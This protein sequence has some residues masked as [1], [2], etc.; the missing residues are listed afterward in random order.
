MICVVNA[1][2]NRGEEMKERTSISVSKPTL[3]EFNELTDKED[4]TGR[5]QD[6]TMK[7]LLKRY[8]GMKR[9][10]GEVWKG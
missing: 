1:Y 4:I 8:K 3:Q 2:K 5:N 6:E 7:R 10:L 9:Q